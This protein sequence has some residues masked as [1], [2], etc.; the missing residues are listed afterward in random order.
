MVQDYT[1]R[2]RV[3]ETCLHYRTYDFT[4]VDLYA[5]SSLIHQVRAAWWYKSCVAQY[6]ICLLIGWC[7]SSVFWHLYLNICERCCS[8]RV[9]LFVL[10]HFLWLI[11]AHLKI[12]DIFTLLIIWNSCYMTKDQY[13]APWTFERHRLLKLLPPPR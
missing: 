4:I 3:I 2:V 13:H 11:E 8:F 9:M 10:W 12:Q 1:W 5:T 6:N 7:E